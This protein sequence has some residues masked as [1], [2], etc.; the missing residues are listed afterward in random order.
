MNYA[1]KNFVKRLGALLVAV[2]TSFGPTGYALA[3]SVDAPNNFD[4]DASSFQTV[5][6]FDDYQ[7]NGMTG[8]IRVTVSV[9]AGAVRIG[10]AVTAPLAAPQGYDASDW[11]SGT[12]DEI[13]FEGV[14]SDINDALDTL[15]YQG[16]AGTLTTTA[17]PSGAAYFADTGNY[18]RY[19][20]SNNVTWTTAE[21]EAGNSSNE[22]NGI[23]G[24]LATIT[25]E[26]EMDFVVDKI[27]GS[28]AAWIGGTDRDVEGEW[29]WRGGD[30][31]GDLFWQGPGSEDGGSAQNGYYHEWCSTEEPNDA[32]GEDY[33]QI[34]FI[35]GSACWN[36]L[37]NSGSGTPGNDP[38][39]FVA[40]YDGTGN[41]VVMTTINNVLPRPV[42]G[43]RNSPANEII[44]AS[45]FAGCNVTPS[46]SV[47]FS[48]SVSN[49]DAADFAAT[50]AGATGVT[51]SSV[52][53]SGTSYTVTLNCPGDNNRGA[54]NLG[55][56]AGQNIQDSD[57]GALSTTSFTTSTG[58]LLVER[59]VLTSVT[60]STPATEVISA[61]DLSGCLQPVLTATFSKSVQNVTAD[62]FEFA[63]AASGGVSIA[64]ISGS[65]STYTITLNCLPSA[66][67]GAFNLAIVSGHD[68]TDTNSV[69]MTSTSIATNQGYFI[70]DAPVLN[71]VTRAVPSDRVIVPEDIQSCLQPQFALTFSEAVSNVDTGDFALS[72]SGAAGL[73]IASVTSNSPSQYTVML[74]CLPA[75]TRGVIELVVDAG[76][77]IEDS[78]AIALASTTIAS[79]EN[80]EVTDKPQVSEILRDDPTAQEVQVQD[81]GACTRLQFRVNFSENVQSV[82]TGDFQISG[83][84]ATDLSVHSVSAINNA[85]YT[86]MLSCLPNSNRGTIALGLAADVS[87]VDSLSVALVY[88][89]ISDAETYI[90][91]ETRVLPSED[92]A[93]AEVVE[94]TAKAPVVAV[95]KQVAHIQQRLSEQR[96]ST[97]TPAGPSAPAA[98]NIA[99][100]KPP[101]TP[102]RRVEMIGNRIQ[103]LTTY[104]RQTANGNVYFDTN[105]SALTPT[106]KN[107]LGRQVQQ[108]KRYK[109][110]VYMIEGHTDKRGSLAFNKKL[111]TKRARAVRQYFIDRGIAEERVQLVSFG[112]ERPISGCNQESCWQQNRRAQTRL[113]INEALQMEIGRE[114]DAEYQV[115]ASPPGRLS[116]AECGLIASLSFVN[117]TGGIQGD[118]PVLCDA[119]RALAETMGPAWG[120]W[121]QGLISV[122]VVQSDTNSIEMD[123]VGHNVT[124][125]MDYRLPSETVIGVALGMGENNLEGGDHSQSETDQIVTSFYLAQPLPEQWAV[126]LAAGVVQSDIKTQ[127]P[128]SLTGAVMTGAREGTSSFG[129]IEIIKTLKAEQQA[130][131]LSMSFVKMRTALDGY[132]ETGAQA[133]A[134]KAQTVDNEMLSLG[135]TLHLNASDTGAG[136]WRYNMTGSVQ[137][138]LSDDAVSRVNFVN[139]PAETDYLVISKN[140]EPLTVSVGAGLDWSNA[141]GNSVKIDYNYQQNAGL[142]KIHTLSAT[143]RKPF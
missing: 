73:S 62:D 3:Q 74:N 60:R 131:D 11:T 44:L 75:A 80:Y 16:S 66:N 53:G 94:A 54:L 27:G 32:G 92:A 99:P 138:D 111:G 36:D 76:N 47:T 45:T 139:V 28:Y 116:M 8:T 90:I 141:A 112:E 58:Y 38:N 78:S 67:R 79:N 114:I 119:T 128:D 96:N 95:E 106:A 2:Q 122:G 121:T 19:I 46:F 25:S 132:R 13:A 68:I 1:L 21:T 117:D 9:D 130:L 40:E 57:G 20:T 140:E 108:M 142:S 91:A 22:L 71:S 129:N 115:E 29:R 5:S 120:V 137:Y 82:D 31:A 102:T 6:D 98:P 41:T 125:G 126:N 105:S 97:T 24:Y 104:F 10:T 17:S 48:E 72:G 133:L 26:D 84:G 101:L 135:G 124:F 118:S 107:T 109:S 127:R 34:K 15:S 30:E 81:I 89:E 86:V 7:V 43:V 93:V 113:V 63:G 83:A 123:L 136:S 49:V 4:G 103:Q 100:Q 35:S 59:P 88:A 143:F 52:S 33:L 42:S 55:F 18:Y 12:A 87:I 37:A 110:A 61:N 65:G 14:L 51:V 23:T 56:A 85:A 69:A 39:G 77:D 50:G 134:F 64:S 70:T